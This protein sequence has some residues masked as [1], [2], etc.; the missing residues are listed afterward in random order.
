[1]VNVGEHTGSVTPSTLHIAVVKVVLPAP[2]GAKKATSLLFPISERNSLAALSRSE[3]FFIVIC[4][5]II[6]CSS[7]TK[8]IKNCRFAFFVQAKK[9]FFRQFASVWS[10]LVEKTVCG[11]FRDVLLGYL[12]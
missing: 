5:V 7:R 11:S 6:F 12:C 1:M 3:V 10:A 9:R 2:I 8:I 4:F